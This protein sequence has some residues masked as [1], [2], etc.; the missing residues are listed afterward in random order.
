MLHSSHY[1]STFIPSQNTL[2]VTRKHTQVR[3]TFTASIE[4]F[5]SPSVLPWGPLAGQSPRTMPGPA[6]CLH[7]SPAWGS[8]R[9]AQLQ[10]LP[11]GKRLT[12]SCSRCSL[13]PGRAF[14]QGLGVGLVGWVFLQK[15]YCNHSREGRLEGLT[16]IL[17]SLNLR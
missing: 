1:K 9:P 15:D 7:Q 5:L 8:H 4:R 13:P 14:T 11:T 10:S 2:S 6:C 3:S 17:L 16:Y 12:S